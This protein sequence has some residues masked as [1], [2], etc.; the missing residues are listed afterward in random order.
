[1][2]RL[3]G[4][5]V[6]LLLLPLIATAAPAPQDAIGTIASLFTKYDV[7]GI[8]EVH[9]MAETH[10]FLRQLVSDPRITRVIDDVVVES[11]NARYQE[12]MD[13]YI[14]GADVP[15]AEV[16]PA[17]R[18]TTMFLVWDSP[19]YRQLFETIRNVNTTLPRAHR[20]RVLLG[21]PPIP[22]EQV[23][24]RA[25]YERFADRD[26]SY[27]EVVDREV[28]AKH[29]KA[30]LIAGAMHVYGMSFIGDLDDALR[31]TSH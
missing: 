21:D 7:V 30:L 26:F 8:P 9:R 1:M 29:H 4:S 10:V 17:W 14:M 3:L 6:F 18:D 24:T 31:C 25:D 28:F 2:K 15:L 16:E 23:K 12:V 20:I 22:W 11:G 27:A 5:V 13:R 19:L